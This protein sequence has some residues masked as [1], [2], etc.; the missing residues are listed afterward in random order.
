M[1]KQIFFLMIG[2]AI[3][4][5]SPTFAMEADLSNEDA[6]KHITHKIDSLDDSQFRDPAKQYTL[7]ISQ[8]M[9]IKGEQDHEPARMIRY[10]FLLGERKFE[11]VSSYL[12]GIAYDI[13]KS[14]LD[15]VFDK[16]TPVTFSA[17]AVEY[18]R[19]VKYKTL[20]WTLT[21]TPFTFE[22]MISTFNQPILPVIMHSNNDQETQQHLF[23]KYGDSIRES[24]IVSHLF[25]ISEVPTIDEPH[26]TFYDWEKGLWVTK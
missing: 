22:S 13:N 26:G 20:P 24:H 9:A 5:I 1:K 17:K 23:A 25:S 6:N 16:D 15:G 21:G 12:K 14:K 18:E 2:A 4:V 10:S 7:T 8:L 19:A 3:A 11:L